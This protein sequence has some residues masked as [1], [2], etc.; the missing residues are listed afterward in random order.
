M[1]RK[2]KS[3]MKYHQIIAALTE[4]PLLITPAAHA[5]LLRLFEEHRTLERAEFHAKR[6]G[7]DYCGNEVDLDQME[8][9][10]GVAHIPIGGPIGF[11]LG[12]FEKGAG[13][14]DVQ[15]VMDDL[16]EAEDDDKVRGILLDIDSPGGMVSGTPELAD[17][18][19]A[20]D[21]PIFAFTSGMMA[22]AAYWIGA[23]AD[24]VFAT[25]SADV[26]SIGVYCPFLD[27]SERLKQEGLKVEVISSGIYKGIGVPGTALTADHRE[28]LQ[29]RVNQIAMM[30]QQHVSDQR[31]GNVSVED[32][33]GQIFMGEDALRRGLIDE[34]VEDKDQVAGML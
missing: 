1:K 12:K 5:S 23:S 34:I 30:F 20:V 8:V 26:G 10:D 3:E 9:I 14:V 33:R 22:S 24:R 18:I 6:E 32:M 25:R 21:K 16:D 31:G 4:E 7:V 11:K 13:A 2:V 29:E 17:R 15:D 19:L 27:S 28:F